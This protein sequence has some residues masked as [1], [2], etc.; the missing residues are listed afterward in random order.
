MNFC[1]ISNGLNIVCN[2]ILFESETFIWL[3]HSGDWRIWE[4]E[5]SAKVCTVFFKWFLLLHKP[6]KLFGFKGLAS[7]NKGPVFPFHM[8]GNLLSNN[9]KEYLLLWCYQRTLW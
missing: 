2:V 4:I 6:N 9:F 7:K 5:M 1:V 8:G 3:S